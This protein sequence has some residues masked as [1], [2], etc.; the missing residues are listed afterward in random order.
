MLVSFYFFSSNLKDLL[1]DC[2]IEDKDITEKMINLL[3]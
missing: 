3:K 2:A 1:N